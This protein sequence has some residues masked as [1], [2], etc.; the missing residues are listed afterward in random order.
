MIRAVFDASTVISGCGWG[1][2]SYQC[3]FFVARRRVRSYATE[4]IIAE[5]RETISELEARGTKFR[6]SPRPTLEWLI[7]VS[8]IISPAP[9]GRQRSRDATDDPYTACALAARAEFIIARDEDLLVL[10]KPFGIEI[11]TPRAF[12]NR[13]RARL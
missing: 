1:A 2:E 5:W 13:L 9:I 3:L 8:H 4:P 10:E 7:G 6:H 12:L 11:L